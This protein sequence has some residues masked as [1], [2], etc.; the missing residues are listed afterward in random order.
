MKRLLSTTLAVALLLGLGALAVLARGGGDILTPAD[1]A[2]AAAAQPQTAAAPDAP[3]ATSGINWIAIPLSNASLVNAS[4]LAT[5]IGTSTGSTVATIEQWNPQSQNYLTYLHELG[6]DDFAL[7]VGGAYRVSVRGGAGGLTWSL[8]GEVPTPSQFT[9]TLY[10]TAS[11][12]INWIMLPLDK[13]AVTLAS[14]L[15]ADIEAHS[16]GA[17][18][19]GAIEQW[20]AAA[21]NYLTYLPE[22]GLDDFSVKI[23]YP[24]RVTVDVTTG[25]SVTW[26]KR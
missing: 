22:L 6:L 10:E 1:N 23:G 5:N 19:V 15:A 18:T 11:S 26:P 25:S 8:V 7:T 12:D 16:S 24:Y 3:M 9:Y 2:V 4:D 17:V 21:Q 20:S 13:N 14:E